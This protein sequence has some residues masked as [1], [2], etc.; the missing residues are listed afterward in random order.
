ME[1]LLKI[2][3]ELSEKGIL[4]SFNGSVRHSIIEEIGKAIKTHL[5]AQELEKGII[6]DVFAVYIEQTQNITNYLKRINHSTGC[7]SQAIII[8]S[9]K[10]GYYTISSGNNILK[11][12]VQKLKNQIELLNSLDKTELRKFYKEQAKKTVN[13]ESNSAGLGLI[14][15]ARKASFKLE[16]QFQ[17]FDDEFDFFNLF[18]TVKGA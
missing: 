10:N 14:D 1:N 6:S 16:Y 2:K 18:V 7:Y 5:E 15:I 9:Q 8:I 4:I 12:D 13:P 17:H 11:S 3:E